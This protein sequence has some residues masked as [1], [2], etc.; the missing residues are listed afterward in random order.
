M[1]MLNT[2]NDECRYPI[3]VIC[4]TFPYAS[5]VGL[6]WEIVSDVKI[7]QKR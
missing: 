4:T 6:K 1:Q 5:F 2:I 7:T 3:N